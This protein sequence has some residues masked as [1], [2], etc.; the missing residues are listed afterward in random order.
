MRPGTS[1][2]PLLNTTCAEGSETTCRESKQDF[3]FLCKELRRFDI[4]ISDI[5]CCYGNGESATIP[6]L[7]S[8]IMPPSPH[9]P[10]QVLRARAHTH[11]QYTNAEQKVPPCTEV[12]RKYYVPDANHAHKSYES[13]PWLSA[14]G[15]FPPNRAA[16]HRG[17]LSTHETFPP[18]KLQNT[19]GPCHRSGGILLSLS[20]C[21]P[22]PATTKSSLSQFGTA[23]KSGGL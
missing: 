9:S 12:N 18:N 21:E 5:R 2:P 8:N 11:T 16:E 15:T 14:R 4:S 23:V 3:F 7:V 10:C 1:S 13:K 22:G 6:A 17:S 19:Q 20:S